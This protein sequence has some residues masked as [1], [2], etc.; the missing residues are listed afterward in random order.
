MSNKLSLTDMEITGRKKMVTNESIH[1]AWFKYFII[2]PHFILG[3][4]FLLLCQCDFAQ[5][6]CLLNKNFQTNCLKGKFDNCCHSAEEC[7]T[8]VW[9]TGIEVNFSFKVGFKY[10]SICSLPE[11]ACITEQVLDPET[12][13]SKSSTADA[14]SASGKKSA[15]VTLRVCDHCLHIM[16]K[17]LKMV[18]E[19]T[20]KPAIVQLYQVFY[21]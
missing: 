7:N 3:F 6:T 1:S 9:V 4:F 14:D 21:Q 10:L 12:K 20:S 2:L 19:R 8:N 13:G 16:K 17:R 11:F 18:R 15:E 5:L